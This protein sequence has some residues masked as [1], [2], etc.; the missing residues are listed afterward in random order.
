MPH[1]YCHRRVCMPP[2]EK[3]VKGDGVAEQTDATDD[4]VANGHEG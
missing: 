2:K 1:V 3:Y 4:N